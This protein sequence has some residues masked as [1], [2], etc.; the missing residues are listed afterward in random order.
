MPCNCME[1]RH[2]WQFVSPQES[3]DHFSR[4]QVGEATAT[5]NPDETLPILTVSKSAKK[6]FL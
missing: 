6:L 4:P 5:S 2:G 1:L 3:G